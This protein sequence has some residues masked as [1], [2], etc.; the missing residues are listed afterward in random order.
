MRASSTTAARRPQ[1]DSRPSPLAVFRARA[2]ARALL[3]QASEFDLH[4]AIDKLQADAVRDGLVEQLGQDEV[5]A[6][7][8]KAF[9]AVRDDTGGTIV[10]PADM[11]PRAAASTVEALM[12][13]LRERGTAALAEADCRR[14]LADLSS[15]QVRV[16][17]GRLMALRPH[18]PAITDELLFLLGEQLP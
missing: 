3:W 18:Y 4:E 16:V 9:A 7:M 14:R 2:E 11:V 10:P 8:A 13:S 6:I 1:P 17:I 5:Q 15:A 12:F